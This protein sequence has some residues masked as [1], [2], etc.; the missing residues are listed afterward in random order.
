[1]SVHMECQVWQ[2]PWE[3]EEC[4]VS[5]E[6]MV[7]EVLQAR[8]A[9]LACRVHRVPQDC[10]DHQASV[11]HKGMMA[12]QADLVGSTRRSSCEGSVPL[13]CETIW[14]KLPK[15][16]VVLEECQDRDGEVLRVNQEMLVHK[17]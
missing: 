1:M 9:I 12:C 14:L 8:Q 15:P 17:V 2:D 3:R 16:S 5:V 13:C 4:L 10:Q 11:G 7:R 6:L